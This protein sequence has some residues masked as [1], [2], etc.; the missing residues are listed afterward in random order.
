VRDIDAHD[1][2]FGA[3]K[4]KSGIKICEARRGVNRKGGG[5]RDTS[6]PPPSGVVLDWFGGNGFEKCPRARRPKVEKKNFSLVIRNNKKGE[7]YE[8][9]MGEEGK[10][11]FAKKS[12][13]F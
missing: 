12:K 1:L 7:G 6:A 10:K 5:D 9:K 13:K 2:M 4:S 3:G 8:R 11:A